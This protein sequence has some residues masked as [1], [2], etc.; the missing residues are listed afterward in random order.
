MK[1]EDKYGGIVMDPSQA[2]SSGHHSSLGNKPSHH[3]F[4]FPLQNIHTISPQYLYMMRKKA[5]LCIRMLENRIGYEMLLQVKRRSLI[6]ASQEWARIHK[7]Q[8][9]ESR[10]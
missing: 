8:L 10:I 6:L 7:K 1:Y 9:L 4:H 3:N 2:S 5:H